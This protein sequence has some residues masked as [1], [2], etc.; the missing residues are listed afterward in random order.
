MFSNDGTVLC[1]TMRK[2]MLVFALILLFIGSRSNAADSESSKTEQSSTAS[3]S[4]SDVQILTQA[5]S[6][7]W[8]GKY[9]DALPL[10]AQL[11]N[12]KQ[13]KTVCESPEN[14]HRLANLADC[15][16]KLEQYDKAQSL[17]EQIL[18][19]RSNRYGV[20]SLEIA[21]NLSDLAACY[22]Y[23]QKYKKAQMLCEKALRIL[24]KEQSAN[25]DTVAEVCLE[26]GQIYYT[27]ANY[28][29]ASK[30]YGRAVQLYDQSK[31]NVIEPLLIALE[32]EAAGYYHD[33]DYKQ[34]APIL[35]RI[36]DIECAMHGSKDVR[37]GWALMNLSDVYRKIGDLKEAKHNYDMCVH[38]F[39]KVNLDRI[40]AE[41]KSKGTLTETAK[42][43]AY[44][45]V[46][47][48]SD[49]KKQ[50][51]IDEDFEKHHKTIGIMQ[52]LPSERSMAKPGPWDLAT[53][54]QIDPPVW[55]WMDPHTSPR[56]VVIC[57]HGLGLNART[58]ESFAQKITPKG[59]AIVALDVRGFGTYT[60]SK[61]KEKIDFE[62]S[63]DDLATVLT[64]MHST[65]PTTPI[66]ILG[67]S[68]GG[69]IALQF[70]AQHQ[71]LVNGLICSVPGG[72]RYKSK[73]TN[74]EVAVRLIKNKHQPFDIGKQ[75]ID[76]ATNKA[77]LRT[78]WEN[79][80]FNRMKLS[81]VELIEFQAFMNQNKGAAAKITDT[82]VIFFQ[83]G[84]D[85][86][87][88]AD[89][90]MQIFKEIPAKDKDLVLIGSSE[91]L[92]FEE[93]Q[94]GPAVVSGVTGWMMGH[95]PEP[96]KVT[97]HL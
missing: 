49:A 66:F 82:P 24:D 30:S 90:T 33:K 88:K 43:A 92:I 56:A 8:Q 42:T 35:Q 45:F 10:Y 46:Y 27:Q 81:P 71:D 93:G 63:F 70:T 60:A 65:R 6:F 97:A 36:T 85:K 61:G 68:M 7:Y 78:A 87:V 1:Q 40:L 2:F 16:C 95:M 58:F 41:E 5:D 21:T 20:E 57:V 73:K 4:D 29:N 18:D 72:S 75:I 69:A 39:R 19:S 34:A 53:T 84:Q 14:L 37:Y 76:Q 3:N 55:M 80:P 38:I 79:D 48:A 64:G 26:L 52:C 17:Y 62:G 47:G 67:E 89:G 51:A 77:S 83:G 59:F 50:A 86:L 31:G 11:A 94:F 25:P 28:E 9:Q 91:H 54:D 32:G 74:M 44:E 13:S 12:T 15:Y 96:A 22:Y 23:Q